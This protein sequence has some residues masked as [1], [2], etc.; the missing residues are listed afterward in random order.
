MKQV[1]GRPNV[2]NSCG[3][4]LNVNH[5]GPCPKCGKSN[6]FINKNLEGGLSFM[7]SL[8]ISYT[9]KFYKTN[10]K[11]LIALICIEF[12]FTFVTYIFYGPVSTLICLSISVL[13]IY[14]FPSVKNEITKIENWMIK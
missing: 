8:S 11:I 10:R 4:T 6:K 13:I 12:I 2:C 5:V 7:G 9:K 3:E 14:L 1:H